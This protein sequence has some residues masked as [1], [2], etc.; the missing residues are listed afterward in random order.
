MVLEVRG[1]NEELVGWFSIDASTWLPEEDTEFD[2]W[3]DLASSFVVASVKV[4]NPCEFF[5][6][7]SRVVVSSFLLFMKGRSDR[8]AVLYLCEQNRVVHDQRLEAKRN[9]SFLKSFNAKRFEL[10]FSLFLS[11]ATRASIGTEPRPNLRCERRL[12]VDRL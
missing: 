12:C 7:I 11:P 3:I 4:S 9:G 2:T 10:R 6:G 5:W 1:K 8:K